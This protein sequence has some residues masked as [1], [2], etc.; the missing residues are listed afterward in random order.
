MYGFT[1]Q[2]IKGREI[3]I[4]VTLKVILIKLMLYLTHHFNLATQELDIVSAVHLDVFN[5]IEFKS[6]DH[7]GER[8]YEGYT[9][10]VN[11]VGQLYLSD[12]DLPVI[13]SW[14]SESCSTLAY[15]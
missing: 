3:V 9:F 6:F 10:S 8:V 2:L 7:S 14:L 15:C 1:Q 13:S 11:L 5:A 12:L 4:K